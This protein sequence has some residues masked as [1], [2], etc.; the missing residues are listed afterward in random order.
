[1][2]FT[3][4]I[5]ASFLATAGSLIAAPMGITVP[6]YF[7]PGPLWTQLNAAASQVPLTAIMNP[8]DGPQVVGA[9][10]T[11]YN[12]VILPLRA[13]GGKVIGYVFTLYGSRPIAEVKADVDAYE[14]KFV[15][16]DGFFFDEMKEA[17]TSADLAYYREIYAYVKGKNPSYHVTANPG[18]YNGEIYLQSPRATDI[19]VTFENKVTYDTA[20]PPTWVFNYLARNFM[21]IPWDVA[22]AAEM[23]TFVRLAKSRNTGQIYV[24]DDD[25]VLPNSVF[26]NPWD[27]LPSYW[28]QEV[29]LVK[30]L[31]TADL[32]TQLGITMTPG[33][34][35]NLQ[36]TGSPGAY[37][38]QASTDLQQWRTLT[39]GFTSTGSMTFQDAAAA[40]FTQRFYRTAQ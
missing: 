38:V 22:T 27:T 1:M 34:L 6:A 20:T 39:T 4:S 31:N 29:Q 11:N 25:G 13:A 17:P 26:T 37:E 24:T 23:D 3:C 28:E 5:I 14:S 8:S 12:N 19:L 33:G 32:P 21:H 16:I 35:A 15:P 9:D 10:I 18:S 2:K 7:Y 36:V 40:T 30:A